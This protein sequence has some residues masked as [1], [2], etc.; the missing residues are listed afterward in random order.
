[1]NFLLDTC[2]IICNI[3]HSDDGRLLGEVEFFLCFK[4]G[5]EDSHYLYYGSHPNSYGREI[6]CIRTKSGD[7]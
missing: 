6:I 1:M 7:I 3:R 2:R 5:L 4:E